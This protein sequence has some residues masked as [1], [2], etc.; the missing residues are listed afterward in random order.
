MSGDE[1]R[2]VAVVAAVLEA[3][4]AREAYGSFLRFAMR[5]A[6][7]RLRVAETLDDVETVLEALAEVIEVG[8]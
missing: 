2:T 8:D 7:G 4:A 3:L 6:A 5:A 1:A